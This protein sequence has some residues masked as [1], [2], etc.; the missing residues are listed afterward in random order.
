VRASSGRARLGAV[1]AR[2]ARFAAAVGS[3]LPHAV[4]AAQESERTVRPERW[5]EAG[6]WPVPAWVVVAAGVFLVLLVV[7][8]LVRAVRRRRR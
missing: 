5:P 7:A 6:R 1:R 8:A 2:I 3:T 4:A